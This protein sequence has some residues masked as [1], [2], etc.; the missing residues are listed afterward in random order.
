MTSAP[1]R[2]ENVFTRGERELDA[3][4]D[5]AGRGRRIA[6]RSHRCMPVGGTQE[7]VPEAMVR[8]Q[9]LR[10]PLVVRN[11]DA[12]L[13]HERGDTAVGHER[14]RPQPLV[15]LALRHRTG[16]ALDEQGEQLERLRG[17]VYFGLAQPELA[18]VGVERHVVEEQPHGRPAGVRPV[19][20]ASGVNT[21]R[22]ASSTRGIAHRAVPSYD[23]ARRRAFEEPGRR[24][25]ARDGVQALTRQRA[26]AFTRRARAVPA[27]RGAAARPR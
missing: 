8:P 15:N 23:K 2:P 12:D 22:P 11:R 9:Q 21:Q 3:G 16:A 7:R 24:R 27:R 6:R 25:R 20:A 18:S 1:P 10:L 14:A 26:R 5:Q 4:P 17:Q 19:Y 13:R